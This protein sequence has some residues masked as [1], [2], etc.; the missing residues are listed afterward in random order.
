MRVK[1]EFPS[2]FIK[3]IDAELATLRSSE[4]MCVRLYLG[5]DDGV[6]W[7]FEDISEQLGKEIDDRGRTRERARQ[8]YEKSLRLLCHPYRYNILLRAFG[9]EGRK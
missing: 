1:H 3:A 6:H 9:M 8:I 7:T 5:F 2:F 4:R